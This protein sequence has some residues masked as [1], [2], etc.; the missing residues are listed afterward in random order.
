MYSEP[1]H[2]YE[3]VELGKTISQT[4]YSVRGGSCIVP[5]TSWCAISHRMEG[6]SGQEFSETAGEA[7]AA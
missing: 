3:E 2:L 1:A 5:I 7:D 4:R 6:M